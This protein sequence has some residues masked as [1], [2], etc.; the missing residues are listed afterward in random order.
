MKVEGAK[1]F[2]YDNP[3]ACAGCAFKA[4]CTRSAFRTLSRW[5]HEERLERMS[6]A[7]AAAPE[8]LKRRKTLIEHCWG[9]MKWLLPGGFL[10]RG[11]QKV[12]A[13]V[14]LA[15]FA[16]NLKRALAVLGLDKLLAALRKK[17]QSANPASSSAPSQP[18]SQVVPLRAMPRLISRGDPRSARGAKPWCRV[19]ASRVFHTASLCGFGSWPFLRRSSVP[20][21]LVW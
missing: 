18:P 11:L 12:G 3:A 21:S 6:A 10:L 17:A 5:E 19:P 1:I 4:K 7:V 16:Y 20:P 14:S 8:K 15:H 13:E 2:N 9:T